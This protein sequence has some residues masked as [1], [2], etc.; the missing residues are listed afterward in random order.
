MAVALAQS[1]FPIAHCALERRPPP[2]PSPSESYV[3]HANEQPARLAQPRKLLV[4]VDLN[5]TLLYRPRLDKAGQ[6]RREHILRPGA[7]ELISYLFD[8]HA[9]MVYTSATRR[10]AVPCVDALLKH[11][12]PAQ[13]SQLI[14]IHPR[15][16]LGLTRAQLNAKVQVYKPLEPVWKLKAVQASAKRPGCGAWDVSNTVLLDDSVEKARA[17]PHSLLQVPEFKLADDATQATSLA[18]NTM[19]AE[20]AIMQRVQARLEQLK[21]EVSVPRRIRIWQEQKTTLVDR[22][23]DDTFAAAAAA[24]YPTPEATPEIMPEATPEAT[25]ETEPVERH[26]PLPLQEPRS[27]PGMTTRN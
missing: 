15:E 16:Q 25:P 6:R 26:P 7:R 8:N 27:G 1:T 13:R 14:G 19:K 3:K 5:G 20:A 2:A 9:V 23:D 22:P 12:A 24:A 11:L 18:A 10:N 17:N 21:W 4:L